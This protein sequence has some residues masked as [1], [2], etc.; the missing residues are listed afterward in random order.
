M[1]KP[2]LEAFDARTETLLVFAATLLSVAVAG[3]ILPLIVESVLFV[4]V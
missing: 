1:M 3:V 4:V 2:F